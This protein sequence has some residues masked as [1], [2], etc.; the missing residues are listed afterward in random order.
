M[1]LAAV[2]VPATNGMW[3]YL[4]LSTWFREIVGN[5]WFVYGTVFIVLSV[6]CQSVLRLQGS[7]VDY[8]HFQAF[9]VWMALVRYHPTE[10]ISSH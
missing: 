3:A 10:L 8:P 5:D 6:V 4:L 9:P 2:F 7:P 1:Q